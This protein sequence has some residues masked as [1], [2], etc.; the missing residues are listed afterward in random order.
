[1]SSAAIVIDFRSLLVP[2]LQY[3]YSYQLTPWGSGKAV[4]VFLSAT[5]NHAHFFPQALSQSTS[6][7]SEPFLQSG[8]L[9]KRISQKWYLP[10]HFPSWRRFPEH[11]LPILHSQFHPVLD[12]EEFY[13]AGKE[14]ERIFHPE[15]SFSKPVALEP[16]SEAMCGIKG[17]RAENMRKWRK[18]GIGCGGN[19]FTAS[20]RGVPTLHQYCR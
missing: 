20:L 4:I 17:Y 3:Q 7:L 9:R 14:E 5:G 15:K 19:E 6:I 16:E 8:F 10:K 18:S 1:M 12:K 13:C 11:F 2:L